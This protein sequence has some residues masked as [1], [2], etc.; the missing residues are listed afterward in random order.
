MNAGGRKLRFKLT[1]WGGCSG[2]RENRDD[3]GSE[4]QSYVVYKIGDHMTFSNSQ[5][6]SRA[7]EALFKGVLLA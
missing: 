4:S 3:V 7:L 5:L 2:P 1:L 6:V